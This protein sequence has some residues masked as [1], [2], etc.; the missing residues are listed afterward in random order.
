MRNAPLHPSLAGHVGMAALA[1]VV[2]QPSPHWQR[3]RIVPARRQV[4][5]RNRRP[6]GLAPGDRQPDG[7][8]AALG[9]QPASGNPPGGMD[10]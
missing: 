6:G 4:S 7:S 9:Q 3:P 10:T 8:R 1:L 2:F 5:W